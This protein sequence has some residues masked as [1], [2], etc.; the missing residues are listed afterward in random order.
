MKIKELRNL[1]IKNYVNIRDDEGKLIKKYQLIIDMINRP[2][3]FI[4]P[5]PYCSRSERIKNI[6]NT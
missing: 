4:N 3:I 2:D 5:I 6:Y 1:A